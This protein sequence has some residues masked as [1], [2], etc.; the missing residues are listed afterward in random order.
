M[1]LPLGTYSFLPWL[2]QGLANLITAADLDANVKIRPQITVDLSLHGEKLGGGGMGIIHQ[3][4]DT[5]LNRTVAIKFLPEAQTSDPQAVARFQLEARTAS[6]LNHA[7]ICTIYDVGDYEGKPYIVMELLEGK[8]LRQVLAERPME[9]SDLFDT[10][11]QITDALEAAHAKGII[12]RDI[13]PANVF[14]TPRGAKVL[15]FG[16]AKLLRAGTLAQTV[17]IRAKTVSDD[18]LTQPGDI[19]GTV[20]HMSPEQARGETIDVRSDLFS[21]GVLMY[22]MA[23]GVQPFQGT[24]AAASYDAILNKRPPLPSQLN[25]RVP[26]ALDTVIY[27]LLQK[28]PQDRYTSAKSLLSELRQLKRELDT[29]VISSGSGTKS[30]FARAQNVRNVSKRGRKHS[31]QGRWPA[32]KAVASSRKNNSPS[33]R[34]LD[35]SHDLTSLS[36]ATRRKRFM[37]R[38]A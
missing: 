12:H 20:S 37:C 8:T 14:I 33:G 10:C 5:R 25:H 30:G 9:I 28:D 16:V 31:A 19:V 17:D 15:D 29:G 6:G 4:D 26:A 11:V 34:S 13:K 24:T 35:C 22:E 23:T 38:I 32:V 21:L 7:N 36:R 1:T 18:Q 3:A 27:K 2:R